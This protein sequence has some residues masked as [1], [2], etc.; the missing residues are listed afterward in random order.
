MS[1]AIEPPREPLEIVERMQ[2][3]LVELRQVLLKPQH[4]TPQVRVAALW[5]VKT[6][7]VIL[8]LLKQ[9]LR[10]KGRTYDC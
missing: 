1:T 7:R 5:R 9:V 3:D 10:T 2:A 8:G 6:L 4:T